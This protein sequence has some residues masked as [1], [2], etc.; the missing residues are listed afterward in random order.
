[1]RF[2]LLMHFFVV[3]PPKPE[4]LH[5]ICYTS[6]TTGLPKGVMLTH[7]NI[8]ADYSGI[9]ALG[10]LTENVSGLISFCALN[11]I[12]FLQRCGGTT[13]CRYHLM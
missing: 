1:L 12:E 11:S 9:V 13:L 6:G 2:D 5:T 7:S 8:V 10:T 3:Q 4:D